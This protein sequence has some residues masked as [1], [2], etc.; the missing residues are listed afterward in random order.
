MSVVASAAQL[1]QCERGVVCVVH[2]RGR[3]GRLAQHLGEEV[4]QEVG[5]VGGRVHRLHRL[6]LHQLVL[7]E[8]AVY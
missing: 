8:H 1:G 6:E 7:R 2:E 5:Q 3:V 4:V